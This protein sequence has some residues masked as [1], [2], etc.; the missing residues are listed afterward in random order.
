MDTLAPLYTRHVPSLVRVRQ[1]TRPSE[2]ATPSFERY[3]RVGLTAGS[4]AVAR[5]I[6]IIGTLVTVPLAL[7]HLG[8]DVYGLWLAITSLTA[9]TGIADLGVGNGL[10]NAV[11]AANA[12]ADRNEIRRQTASAGAALTAA[13]LVIGAVFALVYGRIDWA[14]LFNVST[15]DAARSAGPAV[16][17]FA[18]C[19]LAMLPLS[20]VQR[21]QLGL[22]EGYV[23]GL[24]TAA[25][26]AVGLVGVVVGILAGASLP[27]L[28]LAQSGAP[29]VLALANGIVLYRRKPWLRARLHDVTLPAATALARAGGL[30]FVIQVAIAVAYE[31]D[32]IIV[33]QIL[34]ADAVPSYAV[35]MRL[36]AFAPVALGLVLTPLWPAYRDASVR[37]DDAWVRTAL[38]RSLL[39]AAAVNIPFTIVLVAAGRP[40]IRAWAGDVVTPSALL[41][42]ALACWALLNTIGG[43]LAVLLNGLGAIKFQAICAAAMMVANVGISIAL[44]HALGVSGVVWGTVIA[45]LLFIFVP[46]AIVVPRLL[47]P[48]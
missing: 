7:H 20:L 13:A 40:I 36:F 11:A 41:L 30:F 28:V 48:A 37:G 47:R 23:A 6:S 9:L 15:A 32:A 24:W 25:A 3:R 18:V 39:L 43:P 38:R 35:P 22:Q 27:W 21:I 14:A 10:V 44:T 42:A 16:A 46:S 33:S 4:T 29:A 1:L 19:L 31:S 2:G 45:Q 34:G 8:R 12:R 5:V 17:V 26:A